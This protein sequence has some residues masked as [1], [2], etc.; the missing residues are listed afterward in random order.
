MFLLPNTS[1]AQKKCLYYNWLISKRRNTA[2]SE[3]V[4]YSKSQLKA[5]EA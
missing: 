4:F 5:I 2:M 3:Y 1:I